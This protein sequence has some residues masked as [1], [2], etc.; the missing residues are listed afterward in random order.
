MFRPKCLEDDHV[1][2]SIHEFRRE[3]S[4]RRFLRRVAQS[5]IEPCVNIENLCRNPSPPLAILFISAAPKLEV[6]KIKHREKSTR[7]LSPSVSV[8]LSRMP[9]KSCHS[10]SEAFSI[11]SKSSRDSLSFGVCH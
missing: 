7:R 2:N 6:M 4:P 10:A 1:V 9:S 11:S 5:F 8:A 3:L